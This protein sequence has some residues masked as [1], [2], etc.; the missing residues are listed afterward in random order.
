M[1]PRGSSV[2]HVARRYHG[3][4]SNRHGKADPQKQDAAALLWEGFPGTPKTCWPAF[5]TPKLR[6]S[7]G[8]ATSRKG[9]PV[10]GREG[11]TSTIVGPGLFDTPGGQA[12]ARGICFWQAYQPLPVFRRQHTPWFG[13][14]GGSRGK[15][16]PVSA[17]ERRSSSSL[18]NDQPTPRFVQHYSKPGDSP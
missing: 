14:V 3:P 17:C 6:S 10:F 16:K 15:P 12:M 5:G 11:T 7:P 4:S 8:P 2:V 1:G 9:G 13:S 18:T